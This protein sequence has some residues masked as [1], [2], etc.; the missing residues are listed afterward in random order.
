MQHF[1]SLFLDVVYKFKDVV[2]GKTNDYLVL[3]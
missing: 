3:A 1:N 2:R